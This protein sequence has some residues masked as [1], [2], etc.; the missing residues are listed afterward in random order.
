VITAIENFFLSIPTRWDQLNEG[1]EK[2]S[3]GIWYALALFIVAEGALLWFK[4]FWE[5]GLSY[6]SAAVGLTGFC[7]AWCCLHRVYWLLRYWWYCVSVLPQKGGP[8]TILNPLNRAGVASPL[9][10][11]KFANAIDVHK[12]L[13]KFKVLRS[14]I[15]KFRD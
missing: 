12:A 5:G 6:A 2:T 1:L 8:V 3:D 11:A 14:Q 10:E 15:P 4:I 9:G 13:A 7:A